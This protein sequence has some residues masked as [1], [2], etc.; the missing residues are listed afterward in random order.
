VLQDDMVSDEELFNTIS[1]ILLLGAAFG[2]FILIGRIVDAQR[3]EIGINMALGVSP[4]RIARRYLLIGAQIAVLGTLLGAG[5]GMLI[6]QPLAANFNTML[7]L[8]Y[9]DSSFQ[10][11]IFV[12][13]ALFGAIVSF[14]AVVYP[15][16]RAVRVVPVDAIQTGYL[17]AKGGGLAPWLAR[18]HLPGSSFSLFP[19]RNLSRGPRRTIMTVLG[20]SMAITLLIAVIGMIDTL[21][22]TLDAGKHELKKD[23]PERT[24]VMFDDFYP[25]QDSP[26]S[27]VAGDER[28]AQAVPGIVLPGRLAGE[29]SFDVFIQLLDLDNDLWTPTIVAG[30]KQGAGV[31]ITEKA[32][33]DL[34]VGVG[35]SVTLQ[36]PLRE[37]Q[38]AWKLDQISV[39]VIGLHPD[40]M[41]LAV[42]MDLQHADLLHLDGL[43]N[44]LHVSPAAGVNVQELQRSISQV[45]GVTSVQRV[46]ASLDAVE[47]L[48]EQYLGVFM[49]I[50]FIVLLMA[51]LVA[52]NTTRSNIEERRR[53]LA[54]MFAFGTRVR[55][56]IRM[57]MVENLLT[58]IMGT[59]LG[60]GLGWLLLGNTLMAQFERD[61]PELNPMVNVSASTYGWAVFIGIVVVTV[62]PLLMTRRLTRMDIPSTLRVIE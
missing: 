14:L 34:G 2:A 19:L 23:T 49:T 39:P 25:L 36:Y 15:I 45:G 43:A 13:A 24:L 37:S 56:A 31:L 59:V 28:L 61:A 50:Q 11:S 8:P 40:I 60:I 42:Y 1:S 21:Q 12:Q 33:R 51:F 3:R 44:S 26:I 57:T 53:D 5:L 30:S 58:G 10:T 47:S 18:V 41:R 35:D 46:A 17:V 16:W 4:G 27:Q 9:M 62:T 6:N 55:T 20:L 7:P 22:E 32:A 52:F 38:H 48:L 54:T 29:Q